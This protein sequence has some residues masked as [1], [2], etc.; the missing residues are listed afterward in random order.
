MSPFSWL[1]IVVSLAQNANR[2]IA[3]LVRCPHCGRYY[4]IILYGY[5]RRSRYDKNIEGMQVQRYLCKNPDCPCKTFSQLPHPYL[6]VARIPLCVLMDLY[7][8]HV[9]ENK[10][11]ARCARRFG[12]G[13]NTIKRAIALARRLIDFAGRELAAG[14]MSL[15]PCLPGRWP[16]F[17]RAFSYAF[18]PARF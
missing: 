16:E 14:Q 15:W 13:W 5:Y 11:I 9:V 2:K 7:R 1:C 6:P 18:L 10:T 4:C 12:H 8:L 3:P 17:T